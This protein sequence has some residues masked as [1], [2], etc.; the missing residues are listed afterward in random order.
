[1]SITRKI[2][3]ALGS[4][5]AALSLAAT[6]AVASSVN[7]LISSN[8]D[9]SVR[10]DVIFEGGEAN[11]EVEVADAGAYLVFRDSHP[12]ST[13]G[14]CAPGT[15]D[16]PGDPHKAHCPDVH[17][18]AAA[19]LK[20][21]VGAG[22]NGVA[23]GNYPAEIVAAGSGFNRLYGGPADDV[24]RGANEHD[25][26]VGNGGDDE[27]HGLGGDDSL[28]GGAGGD[29]IHGGSGRDST[30]YANRTATVRATPGAGGAND[31]ESDEGDDLHADVEVVSGG[32]GNDE[33]TAPAG[34]IY[35]FRG[36]GGADQLYGNASRTILTGGAGEDYLEGAGGPDD[37]H[38]GTEDDILHG[39]PGGDALAGGAGTDLVSYSGSQVPVIADLDGTGADDGAAGEGDEIAGDVERLTGGADDD[40]LTGD[41]KPNRIIGGPG[42]DV[43]DGEGGADDLRG[44]SGEDTLLSADGVAD[45]V[46]CGAD[47]D[48]FEPDALDSPL[49]CEIDL[50]PTPP[51]P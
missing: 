28:N 8:P 41:D 25:D 18:G 20:V 4:T 14:Q 23:T 38:G 45:Q 13:S 42:D 3:L 10:Y 17:L 1:M 22:D 12:I 39:G 7:G 35:E 11:N 16:D 43:V 40:R 47:T 9:G 24:I 27:L 2:A 51:P 33:M 5:G 21:D 30:S 49:G 19:K 48:R 44:G 32:S 29:V 36:N 6:P 31:G 50:R 26:L 46:D 34:G 15:P 37:M